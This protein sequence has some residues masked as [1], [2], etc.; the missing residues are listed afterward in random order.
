METSLPIVLH[1]NH[2]SNIPIRIGPRTTRVGVS[3]TQVPVPR[4]RRPRPAQSVAAA[5][6]HLD[7]ECRFKSSIELAEVR[8]LDSTSSHLRFAFNSRYPSYKSD[9]QS[10]APVY[11]ELWLNEIASDAEQLRT[12]RMPTRVNVYHRDSSMEARE[13]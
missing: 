7:L 6:V 12:T 9:I 8:P 10:P 13:A 3:L 11:T 4:I 2:K 5:Q 1:V